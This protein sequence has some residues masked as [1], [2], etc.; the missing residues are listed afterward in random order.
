MTALAK[1]AG[2][3]W[4]N[5]TTHMLV[6]SGMGAWW[7]TSAIPAMSGVGSSR[8]SGA[9]GRLGLAGEDLGLGHRTPGADVHRH[10]ARDYVDGGADHPGE[11]SGLQGTDNAMPATNSCPRLFLP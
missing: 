4:S 9:P 1:M 8:Y 2:A 5:A 10:P 7:A 3:R 6:A 11:L